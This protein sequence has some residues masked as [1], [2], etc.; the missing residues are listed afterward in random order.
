M[1][2]DHSHPV[3]PNNGAI[4]ALRNERTKKLIRERLRSRF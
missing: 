4:K 1:N 3:Y 2:D